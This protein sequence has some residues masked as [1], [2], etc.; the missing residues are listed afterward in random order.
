M[1][2]YIETHKNLKNSSEKMEQERQKYM[3]I[4]NNIQ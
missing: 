1:I 2:V 3:E 4:M